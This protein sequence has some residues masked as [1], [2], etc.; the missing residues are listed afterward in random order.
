MNVLSIRGG[1]IKGIVV[2]AMLEQLEAITGKPCHEMFDFFVGTSTGGLI[3]LAL[4]VGTPAARIRDVYE[5]QGASIFARRWWSY[6]GLLDSKYEGHALYKVARAMLADRRMG[7]AL[8]PVMIPATR[9][10]DYSSTFFKSWDRG[11]YGLHMTNV[12]CATAAAPTFFDPWEISGR[13]KF[14]DGGM[15]ANN[16]A[17][18]A[19]TEAYKMRRD[20]RA[21]RV[22]DLACPKASPIY[23]YGHGVLAFAH[24]IPDVFLESGME[25]AAH[26]CR[27]ALGGDYYAFEPSLGDA[28]PRM[29]DASVKNIKALLASAGRHSDMMLHLAAVLNCPDQRAA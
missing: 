22:F 5:T 21:L 29:D 11:D 28:S 12:A 4:S 23:R 2:A 17:S 6:F 14:M 24:N 7:D 9:C 15:F 27:E 8:T 25:A 3:A 18:F 16:P 19:L 10:G 13:G 1:G 26:Q 20:N